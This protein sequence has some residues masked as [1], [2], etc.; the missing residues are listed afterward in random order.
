M[1]VYALT[2]IWADLAEVRSL[3]VD[4]SRQGKGIGSELVQ[5]EVNEARRLGIREADDVDV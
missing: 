3:A 1:G 5:F 4:P 2:I